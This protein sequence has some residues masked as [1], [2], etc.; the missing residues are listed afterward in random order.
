MKDTDIFMTEDFFRSS[1]LA[2]DFAAKS[3]VGIYVHV[4]FCPHICPYCDFVKT[5]RFSRA[6]VTAYFSQLA[7]QFDR[8]V[9]FVPDSVKNSTLY[10]GGGTPSLFPASFFRPL[11]EKISSRFVIEEFTV[12][13]NPFSN[14]KKVFAEWVELGARRMTLGA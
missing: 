10:L 4:P 11:V 13:T 12:E 14:T 2:L 9:H 3:R 6:D 1:G 7:R 5:S 8:L